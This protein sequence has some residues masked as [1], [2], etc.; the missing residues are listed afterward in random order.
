MRDIQSPSDFAA[1]F[2]CSK[3]DFLD[4]PSEESVQSK[5]SLTVIDRFCNFKQ[6]DV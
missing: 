4:D 2:P 5:S 1:A 6:N 3:S